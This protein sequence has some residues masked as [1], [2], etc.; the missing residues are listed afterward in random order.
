MPWL[1][2]FININRV[3]IQR[4]DGVIALVGIGLAGMKQVVF[5]LVHCR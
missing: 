4:D 1:L 2:R 5:L 3:H